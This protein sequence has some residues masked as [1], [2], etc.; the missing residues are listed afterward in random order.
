MIPDGSYAKTVTVAEAKAMG[1]TDQS[2]LRQLGEDG[3]TSFVY[4][5]QGDRWTEF[6]VEEVPEPGDGGTLEYDANDD[7]VMTSESDGCP[8]CVYTYD[9]S[10][11]GDELTLASSGTSPP[12]PPRTW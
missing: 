2:F 12:T 6:V 3:K 7:V 1:I 9:W 5:F 11:V 8:G 10:L 4:K